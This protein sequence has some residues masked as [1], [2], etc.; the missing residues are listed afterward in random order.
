MFKYPELARK[1]LSPW[2][3]Q[4]L[5]ADNEVRG[6]VERM[7]EPFKTW[8]GS[9]LA[10]DIAGELYTHTMYWRMKMEQKALSFNPANTDSE[11]YINPLSEIRVRGLHDIGDAQTM[12]SL[13]MESGVCGTD[14]WI[15]GGRNI[16]TMCILYELYKSCE[17]EKRPSLAHI[18][19]LLYKDIEDFLNDV[20]YHA[21]SYT[22]PQETLS[23]IQENVK[24]LYDMPGNELKPMLSSVRTRLDLFQD[25]IIA[26]NTSR[27]DIEL[28]S[29]VGEIPFS[30]PFSLYLNLPRSQFCRLLPL[31]RLLFG[32]VFRF[33]EERGNRVP[34]LVV[35]PRKLKHWLPASSENWIFQSIKSTES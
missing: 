13:L 30:K 23:F 11:L 8:T 18:N 28:S 16:L 32:L 21:Y 6:N 15:L 20:K 17:E 33:Q 29:L 14:H 31:Y 26:H 1:I 4:V 5:S 2:L 34:L 27:S 7:K 25:P 3:G 12:A 22:C 24:V 9:I 35:V 10:L 19:S